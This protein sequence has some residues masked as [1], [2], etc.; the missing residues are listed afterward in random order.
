MTNEQI[1]IA[2]RRHAQRIDDRTV[3]R[4]VDSGDEQAIITAHEMYETTSAEYRESI[5]DT[6]IVDR[7][8]QRSITARCQAPVREPRRLAGQEP[9]RLA[10]LMR[11]EPQRVD[12]YDAIAL[13]AW[14]IEHMPQANELNE[15]RAENERLRSD[16]A[17][18]TA[19]VGMWRAAHER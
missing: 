12:R 1:I 3:L 13:A 5:A 10:E 4:I 18:A 17:N 19:I 14:I 2:V 9:W 6:T 8:T 15:M 11:I 7:P 16:L